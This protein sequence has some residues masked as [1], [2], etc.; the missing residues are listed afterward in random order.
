MEID[1]GIQAIGSSSCLTGPGWM[2]WAGSWFLAG[3]IGL[4]VG[5]EEE[6]T[7]ARGKRGSNKDGRVKWAGS[8]WISS[9]KGGCSSTWGRGRSVD[10][11][12]AHSSQGMEIVYIPPGED[13]DD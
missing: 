13:Q 12:F 8:G 11:P 10:T 2:Q 6:R 3:R 7:A 1:K 5:F 4:D 9:R